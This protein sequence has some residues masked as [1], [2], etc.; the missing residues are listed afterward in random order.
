MSVR[1]RGIGSVLAG[2][3][4]AAFVACHD[5]APNLGVHESDVTGSGNS[6]G[7]VC[8]NITDYGAAADDHTDDTAGIKNALCAALCDDPP[9]F[10]VAH[11]DC[12]SAGSGSGQR[13][14]AVCVPAGEFDVDRPATGDYSFDL[15]GT[16]RLT[17]YGTGAASTLAM[18]GSGDGSCSGSNNNTY[19]GWQMFHLGSG[20]AGAPWPTWECNEFSSTACG[21]EFRDLTFTSKGVYGYDDQS[22]QFVFVHGGYNDVAIDR[23]RFIDACGDDVYMYGAT[24][25]RLTNS[26]FSH[27]GREALGL[28]VGA[29]AM[30]MLHNYFDGTGAVR[31]EL[32]GAGLHDWVISGNVFASSAVTDLEIE[33]NTGLLTQ[34][35]VISDNL[36]LGP[37]VAT[38]NVSDVVIRNNVVVNSIDTEN[39]MSASG[40]MDRADLSN[41]VI[42]NTGSTT[43]DCVALHATA[44]SYSVRFAGNVVICPGWRERRS[45]R[46]RRLLASGGREQ[47][48]VRRD[49]VPG[50]DPELDGSDR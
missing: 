19:P 39:T 31:T 25:I 6:L 27:W 38:A 18:H 7:V 23:A 15:T 40:P 47:L 43:H 36:F 5:A 4:V 11:Y 50:R 22:T 28:N 46:Y 42:V 32:N 34:R 24:G 41:N 44:G 21:I 13:S 17:V 45:R 14:H 29:G 37:A 10:C 16:K 20:A 2:S 33:G 3:G 49:G 35:V 30:T 12:G 9:A 1:W 8:A 26:T 48:R